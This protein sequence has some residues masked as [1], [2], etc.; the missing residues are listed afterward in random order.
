MKNKTINS[1]ESTGNAREPMFLNST[2]AFVFGT[3]LALSMATMT[4]PDPD[5]NFFSSSNDYN[6]SELLLKNLDSDSRI[7]T[8]T[9]SKPTEL[10]LLNRYSKI[11]KSAWFKSTYHGQSIGQVVGLES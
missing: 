7:Y 3:T 4:M 11:S 6:S 10:D 8:E 9:N 5:P 2:N 1:T